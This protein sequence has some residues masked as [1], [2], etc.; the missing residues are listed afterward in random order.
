M[1]YSTSRRQICIIILVAWAG[2]YF[3]LGI[4][5]RLWYGVRALPLIVYRSRRH[6]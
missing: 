3:V 4:G 1:Q 2:E 6:G 5:V